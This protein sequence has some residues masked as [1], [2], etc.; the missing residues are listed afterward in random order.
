M[1]NELI[2]TKI[3]QEKEEMTRPNA[4]AGIRLKT[5]RLHNCD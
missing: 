2:I 3:E 4:R 5:R 1:N